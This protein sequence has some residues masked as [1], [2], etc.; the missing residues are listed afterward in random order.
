MPSVWSRTTG[1]LQRSTNPYLQ[2]QEKE[3]QTQALAEEAARET[4][5]HQPRNMQTP[6]SW[7]PFFNAL[8][9]QDLA[10]K[11]RGTGGLRANFGNFGTGSSVKVGGQ[12]V[13]TSAFGQPLSPV[14]GQT[15]G[16]FSLGGS[17]PQTSKTNAAVNGLL[18]ATRRR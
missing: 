16:P 17:T 5:A 15:D 6:G 4:I 7:L 12:T 9:T 10:S 11:M 18:T 2:T 14:I 3:R 8:N 1:V 13:G